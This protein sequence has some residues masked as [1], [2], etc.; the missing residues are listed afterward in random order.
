[1]SGLTQVTSDVISTNTISGLISAG[2]TSMNV[3]SF[4]TQSI[5]SG[6]ANTLTLSANN[7]SALFINTNQNIG[8]GTTFANRL[9]TVAANN[10]SGSATVGI[11]NSSSGTGAFTTLSMETSNVNTYLYSFGDNYTTSGRF[12][13]GSGLIEN[14]GT[15]GI[16]ISALNST[17]RLYTN[18]GTERM[19]IDSA[20]QVGVGVTP[21]TWSTGK[22]VEVGNSGTS[23]WGLSSGTS[24]F[25]ASYYFNSGDKFGV[26][27]NY[28][29]FIQQVPADGSFRFSSST[30]TGTAGDAATMAERMRIT[31]AGN[32]GIGTGGPQTRLHIVGNLTIENSSNAPFIDFVES[33]D[34]TDVKARIQMD[35]VSGTAGQLLFHTEASGTLSERMRITSD[36]NVGIGTS[37]PGSGVRLDVLG[38]EIRAGRVDSSS[39]G[40]QISFSRSSDNATAWYLDVFGNTSTPSFRIVDVSSGAVRATIDGSGRVTMPAQPA[41]RARRATNWTKTGAGT[42]TVPFD[43][44]ITNIGNHY[45]TSNYRFTAP[46]AGMYHFETTVGTNSGGSSMAYYGV[47]FSLNNSTVLDGWNRQETGGYMVDSKSIS[48]YLNQNDFVTVILE[49]QAT[50]TTTVNQTNFSGYLIG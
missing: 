10:A 15:G 1:M 30:A 12:I 36:G 45:N 19:R 49:A 48:I 35:Q 3:A 22:V 5:N 34:N 44:A 33:G 21:N 41:F 8:I 46:V 23:L 31:A 7:T 9:L 2:F 37:S 29:Q 17:I 20:G 32:V 43:T 4:V 14:T 40:G 28:A 39:E 25:T 11:R 16:G 6:S 18:N 42:E 27:G 26:T 13:G 47:I 38:G 24:Y 50:I